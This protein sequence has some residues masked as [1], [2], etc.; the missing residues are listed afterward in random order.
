MIT[1][2]VKV[3]IIDEGLVVLQAE[4]NILSSIVHEDT[5]HGKVHISLIGEVQVSNMQGLSRIPYLCNISA[6]K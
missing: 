4:F 5:D 3:T 6:Y 1:D 2:D